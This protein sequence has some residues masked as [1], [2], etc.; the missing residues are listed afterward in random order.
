MHLWENGQIVTMPDFGCDGVS[1][2][3]AEFISIFLS[4]FFWYYVRNPDT[5][6]NTDSTRTSSAGCVLQTAGYN[7]IHACQQSSK[8][9]HTRALVYPRCITAVTSYLIRVVDFV[10]GPCDL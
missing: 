7:A 5:T 2:S 3:L 1:S 10:I 4:T 8:Q 9:H 6:D